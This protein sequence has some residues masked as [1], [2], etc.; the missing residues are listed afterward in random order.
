[1]SSQLN[2]EPIMAAEPQIIFSI[3]QSGVKDSTT[4]TT[5]DPQAQVGIPVIVLDGE[6]SQ[7]ADLY[8]KLGDILGRQDDA[9]KLSAYCAAVLDDVQ[10]AVADIPDDQRVSLYY[11]EGNTGLQTEPDTSFHAQGLKIAG[12]RNAA[13]DVQGGKGGSMSDVSLEQV[14]AWNPRSSL[15]G[16]T[17]CAAARTRPSAPTRTGRRL[18]P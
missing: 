7:V 1:M 15:P 12:A 16:T 10:A 3:T 14:L 6:M 17:S 2:P 13:N 18:T 4:S 8:T 5:D 11:A 9:A